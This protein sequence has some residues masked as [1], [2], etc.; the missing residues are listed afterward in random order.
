MGALL[1]SSRVDAARCFPGARSLSSSS[2]SDGPP[3]RS[4]AARSPAVQFRRQ[5]V[6]VWAVVAV[7]GAASALYRYYSF[8]VSKSSF[9]AGE[10]A[11]RTRLLEELQRDYDRSQVDVPKVLR[12]VAAEEARIAAEEEA[13]QRART[14]AAAIDQT[15]R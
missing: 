3:P 10:A 2:S 15:G 13:G 5:R 9:E 4:P 12:A 7:V 1:R 14:V 6:N 8:H 11:K